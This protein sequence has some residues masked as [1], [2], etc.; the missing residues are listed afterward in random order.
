VLRSTTWLFAGA[1]NELAGLSP[2]QEIFF[3]DALVSMI[4]TLKG[5]GAHKVRITRTVQHYNR[6]IG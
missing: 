5:G 2:I 6:V 3:G 1:A 4:E